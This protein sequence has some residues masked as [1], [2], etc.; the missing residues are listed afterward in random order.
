[1]QWVAIIPI[2]VHGVVTAIVGIRLVLL[3]LRTRQ[4]PE[5]ALG[6]GLTCI[7]ILGMPLASAGRLPTLIGT[8]IG[9]GLFGVGVALS[10]LGLIL[11]WV[12]TWTVFRRQSKLGLAAVAAAALCITGAA[13]G[14][15][16]VGLGSTNM[17]EIFPR[18]RPFA[19][20]TVTTL[21]LCFLWNAIESTRYS[22]MLER[23][24]ALGLSD[25]VL[26]NRFRLWAA[27]GYSSTAMC[28]VLGV[29]IALGIPPL[30]APAPRLFTAVMSSI[31]VVTWY[32]SFLPPERYLAW[33]RRRAPV[34]QAESS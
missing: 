20:V 13:A 12:F 30:V 3:G 21:T 17:A 34:V 16:A 9:D 23:R 27:V 10:H 2:G 33:V 19:A 7:G 26:A 28:A 29:S 32:L 11:L 24:L 6:F 25:P 18:T 5:L 31:A 8:H 1:M 4:A 14:L 22:R 15:V